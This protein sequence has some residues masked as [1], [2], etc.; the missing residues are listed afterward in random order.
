MLEQLVLSVS[1]FGK[2]F[3]I[4]FSIFK[5]SFAKRKDLIA[6]ANQP[7]TNFKL[8][9]SETTREAFIYLC[10]KNENFRFDDFLAQLP[11]HVKT[12]KCS[13][14]FLTWFIGFVEA[15]GYFASR[16]DH[17]KNLEEI[18]I[19][20][21]QVDP[22]K[23]RVQFQIAQKDPQVL[24]KIR[25]TLGFGRVTS[26]KKQNGNVYYKYYTS[27]KANIL[28]LIHL[29]NGNFILKKRQVQFEKLLA[30]VEQIWEL[31]IP[32]KP[33]N[34][35]PSLDNAWLSGF[36]EGDAGFYTNLGNN[37]YRGKYADGRS[38]YGFFLKFYITQDNAESTLL[39]IRDL[40]K[41]TNKLYLIHKG[42]TLKEYQRLEIANAKSRRLV[43]DYFNRFPLLS[44]EKRISFIRWERI[45]GYQQR[46]ELLTEKSAKKLKTLLLS[47]EE[48]IS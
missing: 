40:F 31:S 4:E 14:N 47:L 13:S 29:F 21:W 23:K 8:G 32:L 3:M 22:E 30:N 7:E 38:R 16:Y 19:I 36:S 24:Y 34:A 2:K 15:E 18:P 37:F 45:H 27:T 28:R 44:K 35:K 48:S 5:Q 6:R 1:H 11:S 46:G 20:Q 33:W 17:E 9:S 25:T 10:E 12:E 41:A 26:F 42:S 43:I 39:Q